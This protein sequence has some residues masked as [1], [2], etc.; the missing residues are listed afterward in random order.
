MH[1]KREGP[2][3]SRDTALENQHPS[4]KGR[5]GPT[6]PGW[7]CEGVDTWISCSDLPGL[8]KTFPVL[9]TG[10]SVGAQVRSLPKK[11]FWGTTASWSEIRFCPPLDSFPSMF[12]HTPQF[13]HLPAVTTELE[14]SQARE[15][16]PQELKRA[17]CPQ[18]MI[19]AL[20]EAAL[21]PAVYFGDVLLHL[22]L[23]LKSWLLLGSIGEICLHSAE[24][25]L[26][27]RLCWEPQGSI[28]LWY[29]STNT[30]T[31]PF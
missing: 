14:L 23:C 22:G 9:F 27:R 11:P 24:L 30:K 12:Y 1:L 6:K 16:F 4:C 20:G 8:P 7:F 17:K 18:K 28:S 5:F 3:K 13:L 25:F 2:W 26:T 19:L 15:H 21:I 29:H 31:S 10:G